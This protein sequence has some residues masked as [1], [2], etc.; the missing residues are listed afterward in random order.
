LLISFYLEQKKYQ[1]AIPVYETLIK[2]Y[3]LKKDYWQQLSELYLRINNPQKALA[4]L[5][6]AEKQGMLTSEQELLRLANLYLYT[7]IPEQ[8]AQLLQQKLNSG[9]IPASVKNWN[10]L[11]DSWILAQEYTQAIKALNYL[12]K[13]DQANGEYQFRIGRLY[14]EQGDWSR[15]LSAFERAQGKKLPDQGHNWLLL[16]ICAYYDKHPD[17]AK[18]AFERAKQ[19]NKYNEQASAWLDELD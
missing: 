16:G 8:A 6:L 17:K 2:R 1:Q 19:F 11:A 4:V 12:V 5:K 7:N 9:V 3:P 13:L 14:M 18:M 15:A 10:K